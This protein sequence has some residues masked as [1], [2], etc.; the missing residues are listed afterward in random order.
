[1]E[2]KSYYRVQNTMALWPTIGS[3]LICSCAPIVLQDHVSERTV[4]ERKDRV[5]APNSNRITAMAIPAEDHQSFLVLAYRSDRC[6]VT[7]FLQV[8]SSRDIKRKPDW[9]GGLAWLGIGALSGGLGA[10]VLADASN[11][12]QAGD[13]QTR[14]PVGRTGAYGIGSGLSI[15]GGAALIAGL[16]TFV[17]GMDS[18]EYLGT[19]PV[20]GAITVEACNTTMADNVQV[21]VIPPVESLKRASVTLGHTSSDGKFLI[22]QSQL[23]SLLTNN[24]DLENIQVRVGTLKLDIELGATRGAL[25]SAALERSVSL[26]KVDQVDEGQMELNFAAG[27]G[28]DVEA[29]QVALEQAPT[30]RRRAEDAKRKEEADRMA[31]EKEKE[32]K[33]NAHL[34]RARRFISTNN[35]E[36]A[37]DE[38]NLAKALGADVA[39]LTE[40]VEKLVITRAVAKWRSHVAGCRKVVAIRFKIARVSH[41]DDECKVIKKRVD[42]EWER[43]NS[44]HLDLQGIPAD[45]SQAFREMCQQAGCP[46]CP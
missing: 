15:A 26:A 44:E 42:K 38:L 45:Q 22:S 2:I 20:R 3:L 39:S 4:S 17:R 46:N 28:G 41:C 31:A 9:S 16:V 37:Q 33:Y 18:Q 43:L 29:A 7:S 1:M 19:K 21:E 8:K 14:N 24:P 12:P 23:R 36:G 32:R 6:E 40:R 5:V 27:L 35:Y 34:L 13:P 11:V 25:A 10:W 30:S